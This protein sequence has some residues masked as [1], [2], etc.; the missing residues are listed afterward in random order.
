[1]IWGILTIIVSIIF[2]MI[3]SPIMIM[4][5]AMGTDDPNCGKLTMGICASICIGALV[6]PIVLFAFGVFLLF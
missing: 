1:M 4:V 6:I 2:G 3:V 5:G